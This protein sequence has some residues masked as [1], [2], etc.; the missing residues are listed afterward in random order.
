MCQLK[1]HTRETKNGAIAGHQL[2]FDPALPPTASTLRYIYIYIYI[3]IWRFIQ[4]P[5]YYAALHN[6]T[7]C[8]II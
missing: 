2:Y 4:L 5:A 7:L 8:C 6:V 1:C 3:L